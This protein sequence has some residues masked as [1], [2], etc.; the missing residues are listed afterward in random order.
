MIEK[1]NMRSESY[2]EFITILIRKILHKDSKENQISNMG[3]FFDGL[4]P[5]GLLRKEQMA[6]WR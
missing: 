4:T 5:I 2:Y 1:D 3:E 6:D